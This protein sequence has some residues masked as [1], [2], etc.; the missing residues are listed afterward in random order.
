M[1][2]ETVFLTPEGYDRL[3]QELRFLIEVR[4][5]EVASMIREAKE[6]GD[7]S[8]N[9]G[10][11]EAKDQQAFVEA[12]IKYIDDL[13]KRAEVIEAPNG[14]DA[15]ALGSHVTVAEDGE[16]PESFRLVGAAEADPTQGLI[17]NESPLGSA[18]L[19][20]RVGESTTITTPD[21]E[22]LTFL[23]LNIA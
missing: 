6:A 18:L 17:S 12:R 15:V 8:E 7:V 3:H 2:A 19:G 22:R 5:A 20:K 4:R 13:L 10:Y 21:G 23:V 1:V 11:D 16:E 14:N 9:A